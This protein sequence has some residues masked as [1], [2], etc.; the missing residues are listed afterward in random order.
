MLIVGHDKDGYGHY[1]V[2]YHGGGIATLYAHN[3]RI[4]VSEEQEVTTETAI[5]LSG[6]TGASTGPHGVLVNTEGF[7]Y[8]RYAAFI[9]GARELLLSEEMH[10]EQRFVNQVRQIKGADPA[11]TPTW[12]EH[13]R[14]LAETNTGAYGPDVHVEYLRLLRDCGS[15]FRMMDQRYAETLAEIFNY[16]P[17][18]QPEELMP[19][20]HW[21]N[22][23]GYVD[24]A[25]EF[26][27]NGWFQPAYYAADRI[28]EECQQLGDG[29]AL[30]CSFAEIQDAYGFN[31][32]PIPLLLEEL[33]GREGFASL[34]FNEERG[35]FAVRCKPYG[36]TQAAS[37]PEQ[38]PLTQDDLEAICA[39]HTLWRLGQPDGVCADFSGQMLSGLDF[40]GMES[41][42]AIFTG[43]TIHQCVFNEGSFN[44]C[45]FSGA[46]LDGITAA[47]AWFY[48]ADFSDADMKDC[49]F[50]CANVGDCCFAGAQ[51]YDSDFSGVHLGGADFSRVDISNCEGFDEISQ[52]QAMTME[53]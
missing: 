39:R 53:G 10:E 2:M 30:D 17:G 43:A 36:Q 19:V 41:S 27:A 28:M 5:A 26:A 16:K 3:S 13:I 50:S 29:E 51:I 34:D 23:G 1:C 11:N 24:E 42:D 7:D 49:D 12:F 8:A 15:A 38:K 25:H 21:I 22:G 20:A 48:N 40:S 47:D 33:R 52:G 14:E 32:G 31:G 18:Y 46:K 9:P 6:N 37:T 45:N 4:L 44:A 35:E